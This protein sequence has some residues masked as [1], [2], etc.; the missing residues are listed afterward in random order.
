MAV[1]APAGVVGRVIV[2][3]ARAAK[4]Q[5]LIDRNA[6]AGAI[7]ER[8]SAPE[9]TCVVSRCRMMSRSLT[10]PSTRRSASMTGSAPSPARTMVRAASLSGVSAS[11]VRGW[12]VIT[13][14]TVSCSGS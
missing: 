11:T 5:L 4:V 8:T 2:P 7:I 9:K 1:L 13:S 10:M 3:S 12:S 6:A 14:R